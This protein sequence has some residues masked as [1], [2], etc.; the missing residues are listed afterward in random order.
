MSLGRHLSV[1]GPGAGSWGRTSRNV[2]STRKLCQSA[3]AQPSEGNLCAVRR[4]TGLTLDCSPGD[5]RVER[6]AG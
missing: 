1:L 3:F 4:L 5:D 2:A 6:W